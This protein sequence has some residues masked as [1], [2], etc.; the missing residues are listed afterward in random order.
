MNQRI[1]TTTK[2]RTI[3]VWKLR[4]LQ[5]AINEG[6]SRETI[7]ISFRVRGWIV[8][9][10]MFCTIVSRR[11]LFYSEL[12]IRDEINVP[13]NDTRQTFSRVNAIKSDSLKKLSS[14]FFSLP[15]FYCACR[16][17]ESCW[18]GGKIV[19]Q[20]TLYMWILWGF[21]AAGFAYD[22]IRAGKKPFKLVSW[23]P[24]EQ[25]LDG[26]LKKSEWHKKSGKLIIEVFMVNKKRRCRTS[27]KC[28]FILWKIAH[29]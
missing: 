9:N 21:R 19:K 11:L 29:S 16:S 15:L 2:N 26:T 23:N 28:S 1:S 25:K 22:T 13:Q 10:F 17:R 20:K 24:V 12:I 8:V 3:N 7:N 27:W 6:E 4:L 5:H 18:Y 14:K